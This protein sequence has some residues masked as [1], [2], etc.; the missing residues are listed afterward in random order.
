[1]L[2][3]A[4]PSLTE[5]DIPHRT[6]LTDTIKSRAMTVVKTIKERL[7]HVDSTISMTFD[8]WTSIIGEPFFFGH[9]PLHLESS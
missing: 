2:Q 5:K 8:S 7:A 4:R 6:K 9:G 3:Y 1:L